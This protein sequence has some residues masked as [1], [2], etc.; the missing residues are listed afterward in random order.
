MDVD[1][2]VRRD[3]HILRRSSDTHVSCGLSTNHHESGAKQELSALRILGILRRN[4]Q[5][6]SPTRA[7][8]PQHSDWIAIEYC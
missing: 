3:F 1:F 4:T 2:S 5:E 7:Q 8:R 6:E